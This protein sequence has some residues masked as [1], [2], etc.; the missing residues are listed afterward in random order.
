MRKFYYYVC[1]LVLCSSSAYAQSTLTFQIKQPPPLLLESTGEGAEIS[2]GE[3]VQLGA[4]PATGGVGPYTYSWTPIHGLDKADI[5]NPTATPDSTTTYTLFISDAAGCS[6]TASITVTVNTVTGIDD[7]ADEYGLSVIPNP[8]N[9]LFLVSIT[10]GLDQM[11]LLLEILDPVGRLVY[12]ERLISSGN[13][14]STNIDLQSR[15]QGLYILR[16]SGDEISIS[17]KVLVR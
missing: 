10:K 12:H 4:P 15:G 13:K 16:L 8:N 17:R 9:G 2:K 6:K 1:C 5:P 11:E 14:I 3:S 7:V